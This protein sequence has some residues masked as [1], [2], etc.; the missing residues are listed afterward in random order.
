MHSLSSKLQFGPPYARANLLKS[1]TYSVLKV[2]ALPD[3]V[4]T[5]PGHALDMPWTSQ[6]VPGTQRWNFFMKICSLAHNRLVTLQRKFHDLWTPTEYFMNFY[7][8]NFE[9]PEKIETKP[10]CPET[11]WVVSWAHKLHLGP[12]MHEPILQK[13]RTYPTINDFLH[14]RKIRK[15][16]G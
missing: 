5:C 7:F 1:S 16:R 6:D 14:L 15:N 13:S 8:S 4:R 3:W 10:D 11:S 9:N 2:S 12:P